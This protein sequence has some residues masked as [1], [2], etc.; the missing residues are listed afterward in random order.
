VNR[1]WWRDAKLGLFIHWGPIS[2]MGAEITCSRAESHRTSTVGQ[3]T[4]S[5]SR[6][7][8]T[9]TS[10]SNPTGFD[11]REWVEIAKTMGARYLVFTTKHGDGFCMFDSKL[12]DYKIT[13]SPFKRTLP[14][15]LRRM[16]RW[17][18]QARV[19]LLP[20]RSAPSRLPNRQP[21]ALREYM[22][23][24][25]RELCTNY[26]QVDIVWFDSHPDQSEFWDS[27]G[28]FEIIR[29]LQPHALINDRGGLPGD[30]STPEQETGRFDSTRPWE[31][32][33]TIGEQWSYKP[34]DNVKSA[35]LCAQT[36][37]R[38]ACGDG[39][40]L[41]NVGPMPTARSSRAG[42]AAQRD[43]AMASEVRRDDIRHARRAVCDGFARGSTYNGDEVCLHIL[44]WPE[45]VL[46][47]PPIGAK[48]YHSG[49]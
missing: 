15:S 43:G 40:L 6:Y 41:L 33:I 18:D 10:S 45:D 20:A 38:C 31:S 16:P 47:L 7:T 3:R 13:N 28:M 48:M 42:P 35:R 1:Q 24:Q 27:P 36:L 29:S 14:P 44:D 12:T 11:A 2:L 25:I 46:N 9:S 21:P 49:R 37:V 32:C 34:D 26:G 5:R 17:R 4:P 39:N 23:G 30:F 19:L 8:I 22:H